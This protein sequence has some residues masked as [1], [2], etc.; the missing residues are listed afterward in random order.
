MTSNLGG[1]LISEAFAEQKDI[2]MAA[3]QA[4]EKV[5]ALLKQSVRPEFLNRIDD[6]VLFHPLNHQDVREIVELQIKQLQKMLSEQE[7]TIDAT[8][9]AIDLLAELGF[10]PQYG[11]RPIK[12]MIQKKILNNLSKELLKGTIKRDSIVLID[13]FEEELVFRNQEPIM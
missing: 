11:A 12:R 1:H 2:E 3:Q 5:L 13:A 7:I 6:I 8:P 10:D 9:E 4:Q